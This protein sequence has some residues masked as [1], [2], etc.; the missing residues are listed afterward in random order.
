MKA[1]EMGGAYLTHRRA[2]NA[3]TLAMAKSEVRRRLETL[4]RRLDDNIKTDLKDE[5]WRRG[6]DLSGKD[7]GHRQVLVNATMCI[8]FL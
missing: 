1:N 5:R 2:E 3:C 8:R 7:W 6:M 4:R